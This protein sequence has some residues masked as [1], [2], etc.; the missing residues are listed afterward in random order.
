MHRDDV[1][2]LKEMW[3]GLVS[4]KCERSSFLSL[5][6]RILS[7]SLS[8]ARAISLFLSLSL[9]LSLTH[10]INQS[11]SRAHTHSLS[12]T[13]NKRSSRHRNLSPHSG[14]LILLYVF[15]YY[16]MCPHAT[17]YVSSGLNRNARHAIGYY[18]CAAIHTCG[19]FLSTLL[20]HGPLL[21]K[22]EKAKI[23]KCSLTHSPPQRRA[24]VLPLRKM[25]RFSKSYPPIL[26]CHTRTQ[27]NTKKLSPTAEFR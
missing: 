26:L 16:F 23:Q 17:I 19:P 20:L 10:S 13:G 21:H 4:W 25:T 1:L 15:S 7:L 18:E 8:L 11:R 27:R 24:C 3:Y 6:Y 2:A 12:H 9:S 14:L 5:S 22:D